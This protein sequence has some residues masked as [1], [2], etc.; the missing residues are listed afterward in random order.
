MKD[1]TFGDILN[2]FL[3]FVEQQLHDVVLEYIREVF[4]SGVFQLFS[5]Q[6]VHWQ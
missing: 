4:L 1:G 3:I 6:F 2:R 5:A